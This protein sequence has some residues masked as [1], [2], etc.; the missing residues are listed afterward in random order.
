[1]KNNGT[2]SADA[3]ARREVNYRL[4]KWILTN[5]EQLLEPEEIETIWTELLSFYSPWLICSLYV[6]HSNIIELKGR[7]L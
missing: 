1:M 6:R 4:S 7:V 3:P 5:I 2:Q